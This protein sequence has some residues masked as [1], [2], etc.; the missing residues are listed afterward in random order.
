MPN[1]S[2]IVYDGEVIIDLTSDTVDES[3][4]YYG[5][6]AHTKDGRAITG[7]ME[8]YEGDPIRIGFRVNDGVIDINPDGQLCDVQFAP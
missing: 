6:K 7:K 1:I 8:F 4:L 2:K 5:I 3:N